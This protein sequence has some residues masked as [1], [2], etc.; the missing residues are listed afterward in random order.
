MRP[1]SVGFEKTPSTPE[2]ARDERGDIIFADYSQKN[3]KDFVSKM[4]NDLIASIS[5]D[6]PVNLGI[7]IT[8]NEVTNMFC[9]GDCYNSD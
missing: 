1:Q 9:T 5:K 4:T 8:D 3:S 7:S 6:T 2:V